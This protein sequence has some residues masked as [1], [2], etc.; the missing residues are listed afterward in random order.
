MTIHAFQSTCLGQKLCRNQEQHLSY[1]FSLCRTC[2]QNMMSHAHRSYSCDCP[3]TE[4]AGVRKIY[5]QKC[6]HLCKDQIKILVDCAL[7]HVETFVESPITGL[8]AGRHLR[9]TAGTR[10]HAMFQAAQTHSPALAQRPCEIPSQSGRG[11]FVP[12]CAKLSQSAAA[13][14]SDVPKHLLT[15]QL[16]WLWSGPSHA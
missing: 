12:F 16:E 14:S 7:Q 11:C 6:R 3:Q 8:D 1:W 9:N 5:L 15:A 2:A 13:P 4:C 10:A